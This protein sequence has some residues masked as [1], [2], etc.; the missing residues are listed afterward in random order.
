ML[1][2]RLPSAALWAI[3]TAQLTGAQEKV[4]CLDP[5][6]VAL[7]VLAGSH[8]F[9]SDIAVVLSQNFMKES[10]ECLPLVF[11]P[12]SIP[13][14]SSFLPSWKGTM[15]LVPSPL[16]NMSWSFNVRCSVCSDRL[17]LCWR[18]VV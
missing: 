11:L 3:L 18:Q 6:C 1:S 2:E 13:Q 8:Y 16:G 9:G 10:Q 15:A 4:L 14:V 7:P 5:A 17:S 12:V